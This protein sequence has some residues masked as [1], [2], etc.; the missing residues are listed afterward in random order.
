MITAARGKTVRLKTGMVDANKPGMTS[1][2]T[3]LRA[4]NIYPSKQMGQNFLVDPSTAEMIIAKAA[5][6]PEE[7]VLEIGS[8]LGALT[9]P[10]AKAARKV[11]AVEKDRRIMDL[12]KTEL[13]SHGLNNIEILQKN[14]LDVDI[15]KTSADGKMVVIGNLPYNISS[16]ILVMLIR[17]KKYISRAVLMFQKE[18]CQRLTAQPGGRQYGR[19][20]VMLR[21]CSEITRIAGVK[22]NM[23]FPRPSI[24]SEVIEIR[25]INKPQ[26]EVVSEDHLF[27]V[28]KSAFSKRRKT[29]KNS[30]SQ[31][32]LDIDSNQAA[33]LLEKSG[34]DPSRRAETLEIDDFV[35]L[36]AAYE[37]VL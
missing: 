22:S 3:L 33:D 1:P 26:Y 12:L 23:F 13:L 36:T 35:K 9:I 7:T 2:Q 34:I 11:I 31:S 27:L 37:A 10:A 30:L 15:G 8:G 24:D 29:L 20:T 19:I 18:L 21:Y 32:W 25:F 16:Q 6:R 14:I 4:W 17:S 5:I 28:I